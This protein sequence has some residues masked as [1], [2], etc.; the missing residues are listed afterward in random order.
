MSAG[1]HRRAPRGGITVFRAP[2]PTR[3]DSTR[4]QKPSLPMP[5]ANAPKRGELDSNDGDVG[6][7][8]KVSLRK[9]DGEFEGGAASEPT[10]TADAPLRSPYSV[11]KKKKR[12]GGDPEKAKQAAVYAAVN[13]AHAADAAAKVNALSVEL[14]VANK[15]KETELDLAEHTRVQ[16][17]TLLSERA[18]TSVRIATL[19]RERDAHEELLAL[20]NQALDEAESTIEDLKRLLRERD[21]RAS[22]TQNGETEK[23]KQKS[24]APAP[25]SS[26]SGDDGKERAKN[27]DAV[28]APEEGAE[29]HQGSRERG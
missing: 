28:E 11:M 7:P 6:T 21:A 8:K 16:L 20:Q 14:R 10:V 17:E 23:Q 3:A 22:Q 26:P 2:K 15:E 18:R 5:Q 24:P 27:T 12:K 1:G 9:V 19:E 4:G 25:A 13:A 29:G